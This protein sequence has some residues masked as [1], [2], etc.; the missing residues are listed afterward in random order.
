[1]SPVK[2]SQTQAAAFPTCDIHTQALLHRKGPIPL[3]LSHPLNTSPAWLYFHEQRIQVLDLEMM[4][5]WWDSIFTS[6]LDVWRFLGAALEVPRNRGLGEARRAGLQISGS[7]FNQGSSK[8]VYFVFYFL[9]EHWV[10]LL[11]D[12]HK[13]NAQQ[14]KVTNWPSSFLGV[15]R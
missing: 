9:L 14:L 12:K 2:S 13:K 5:V 15:I 8:D 11:K 10:V 3:C 4:L 6:W 1:M 7:Y